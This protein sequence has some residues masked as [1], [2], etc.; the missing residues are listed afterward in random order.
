MYVYSGMILS[1]SGSEGQLY[2]SQSNNRRPSA[3]DRRR[4]SSRNAPRQQNRQQELAL[5]L[6]FLV[7]VQST[8]ISGS[9]CEGTW[10]MEVEVW[11]PW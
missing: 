6:L 1:H 7:R 3:R 11:L 2:H 4:S 8:M 5:N 9:S 10:G